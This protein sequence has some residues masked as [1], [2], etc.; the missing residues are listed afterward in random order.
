MRKD[1]L[2]R[3]CLWVSVA[4]VLLAAGTARADTITYDVTINTSSLAPGG[5]YSLYFYL[6]DGSGTNDGNNTATLS[7]FAFGGG[8]ASSLPSVVTLIDNGF[9]NSFPQLFPPGSPFT[10]GN[11]LSFQLKD[12]FGVDTP[13]PDGFGLYIFDSNGNPIWYVGDPNFALGLFSITF[14][15]NNPTIQNYSPPDYVT[16]TAIPEPTSLALFGTGLLVGGGVLR[17]KMRLGSPKN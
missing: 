1:L 2:Q 16:L 10:A 4:V 6:T 17:R 13:T 3:C 14:D 15:S 11:T 7:N 12:V 8:S 5:N 9:L